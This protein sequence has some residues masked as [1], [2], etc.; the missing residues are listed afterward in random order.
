M[1][2]FFPN[3]TLEEKLKE[4]NEQN[5]QID[6]MLS[7]FNESNDKEKILDLIKNPETN[8]KNLVNFQVT[9]EPKYDNNTNGLDECCVCYNDNNSFL[10][11][12]KC[13][14]NICLQCIV[15]LKATNC[16]M[17]RQD[18]PTEIKNILKKNQLETCNYTFQPVDS[19]F[20]WD[21]TPSDVNFG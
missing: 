13:N 10:M 9:N 3:K 14:H 18:F 5:K 6:E 2:F 17:C 16:P 15:Q 1:N 7:K 19:Y 12:T 8:L 4:R 21:G 20:S 11:K